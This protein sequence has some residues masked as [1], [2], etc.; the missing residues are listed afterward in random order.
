MENTQSIYLSEE[1]KEYYMKD[2]NEKVLTC[3]DDFWDLDEGLK[4][5]LININA[6]PRVQTL[7][8]KYLGNNFGS[9]KSYLEFAYSKEIEQKLLVNL[10]ELTNKYTSNEEDDNYA[11]D[12]T[13][14]YKLCSPKE[15]ANAD[16]DNSM[17]VIKLAS[18]IDPNYFMVNH[19]EVTLN[20]YSPKKHQQFWT[21]LTELLQ[22]PNK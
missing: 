9:R 21:D 17:S 7:Y 19:I 11:E 10:Q 15:N 16:G 5:L 1:L 2:F 6:N 12:E 13:C 3:D 14:K 20:S 8:S 18:A 4:E 22:L